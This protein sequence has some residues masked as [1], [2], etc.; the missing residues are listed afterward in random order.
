MATI[1]RT[2]HNI[3]LSQLILAASF[4]VWLLFFP[5]TA[6][7]FAWPIA[8]PL[9]AMFLGTSFILRA[10]Q[11]YHMWRAQNWYRLRWIRWGTYGFLAVIFSGTFWHVHEMNWGTNIIVAHIWVLAYIAEPLILPF[12]EPRDSAANFPV[13]AEIKLG[14]ILPGLQNTLIIIIFVSATLGGLMF[15]NPEFMDT[16][17]SWS[18]APFDARIMAAFLV[19]VVLWAAKMKLSEDWIEIRMGI[20]GFALYASVLFLVWGLAMFRGQIDLGRENVWT[21]GIGT[22]VMAGLLIY[23][24]Q[25]Q[26][27][28]AKKIQASKMTTSA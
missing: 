6:T 18:L 4:V 27:S 15:I 19:G 10:F 24:Y 23:Y 17:W 21:Y 28:A 11:G 2:Y 1:S 25:K 9:S 5:E 12:I 8:P 26:E 3:G 20:Q 14:P 7:K 16:R 13:P 22:A